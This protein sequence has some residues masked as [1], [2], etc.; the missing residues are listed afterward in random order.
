MT[1]MNKF[2]NKC[3]GLFEENG[4]ILLTDIEKTWISGEKDVFGEE[5]VNFLQINL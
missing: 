5:E 4:Q 2:N 1:D 3:A